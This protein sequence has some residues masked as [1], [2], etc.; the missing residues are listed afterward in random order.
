MLERIINSIF[1]NGSGRSSEEPSRDNETRR[2]NYV[3][4]NAGIVAA[5]REEYGIEVGSVYRLHKV[6]EKMGIVKK[7]NNGWLLTE[8]GRV[9][10]TGCNALVYNP[11]LWHRNIVSDI[12]DYIRN[13]HIDVDAINRKW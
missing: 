4:N 8:Y 12:A 5:L 10:Y 1:S 3:L 2:K 7:A 11:D 6:M 13:N 9:T